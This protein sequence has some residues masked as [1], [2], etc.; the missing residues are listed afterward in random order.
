MV[1]KKREWLSFEWFTC[2][3]GYVEFTSKGNVWVGFWR[4]GWLEGSTRLARALLFV[5]YGDCLSRLDTTTC[6]RLEGEMWCTV[7]VVGLGCSVRVE[8]A[9][10][11]TL[12]SVYRCTNSQ[13]IRS[14]QIRSCNC[15]ARELQKSFSLGSQNCVI[16]WEML[17]SEN[18]LAVLGQLMLSQTFHQWWTYPTFQLHLGLLQTI[19]AIVTL[20]WA[21]WVL[22]GWY[23]DC[24]YWFCSFVARPF[25]HALR[26]A[27]M[28]N[29]HCQVPIP[30]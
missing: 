29:W 14:D 16:G 20:L 30:W 4:Q 11:L 15:V 25:S 19:S 8:Y 6:V 3:C 5:C 18:I 2:L 13:R 9:K 22:L 12:S 28:L 21:C 10:L 24:H 27:S 1:E 7:H 17:R 26:L 23:S